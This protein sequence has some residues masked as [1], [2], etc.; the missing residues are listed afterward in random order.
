LNELDRVPI[1]LTNTGRDPWPAGTVLLAGWGVSDD[2]YLARP[3]DLAALDVAVPAVA[4]G[5]SVQL[6]V[7]V[8]PP[9]GG[10]RAIAWLTLQVDGVVLSDNGIPA[11]QFVLEGG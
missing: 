11:S 8:P 5:E 10:G 4:P 1:R 9:T 7:D 2:P 3:P 6:E